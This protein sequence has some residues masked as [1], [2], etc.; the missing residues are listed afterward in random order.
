MFPLYRTFLDELGVPFVE[1]SPSTLKDLENL[2]LCPTDEPCV[3]VKVVFPHAAKLLEQGVDAL[4]IPTI[5][6]LE[7]ESFCC[8]KMMGLPSMIKSG[9]ELSDS[10]IISPVIDVR[11]NPRRW[12]RTWI[13]A[14]KQM[15]IDDS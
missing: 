4:F 14:G 15:G 3:S 13:R 2:G 5:V 12:P 7:K 8:P 1:T 10:Q 11:D 9:F 6:S